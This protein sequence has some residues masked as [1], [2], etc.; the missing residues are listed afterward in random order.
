MGEGPAGW[1]WPA[2]GMSC[3]EKEALTPE[4]STALKMKVNMHIH[5]SLAVLLICVVTIVGFGQEI[6]KADQ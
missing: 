6:K 2:L 5:Y 1:N 4:T 3:E